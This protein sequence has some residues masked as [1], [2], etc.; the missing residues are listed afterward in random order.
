MDQPIDSKHPL[1][2]I[3]RNMLNRCYREKHHNFKHYGGR[4]ITVCPQWRCNY[5]AFAAWALK[6]GWLSGLQI[7]RID[8]D[9]PYS[10]ENCRITTHTE[11]VRN[12]RAAK[13]THEN[14]AEIQEMLRQGMTHEAIS[15]HYPVDRSTITRINTGMR[16]KDA[17]SHV[18][19]SKPTALGIT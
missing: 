16:W 15:E 12:S 17:L 3:H 7:D 4:G 1:Y 2:G 19:Q 9:G 13:L 11:N 14:V 5:Y 18:E 10:P 8:N 6:N